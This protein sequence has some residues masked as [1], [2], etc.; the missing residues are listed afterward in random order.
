MRFGTYFFLQAT[1]DRPAAQVVTDEVA[2]MVLSEQLGFDSVWLTEHH[3]ADYGLSAAPSVL[4]ATVAARTTRIAIGTAVYVLPFQ[5][6][7]RLAEE[8]A[9]LDILSGGRLIVGIGRGN[10][11]REFVGHGIDQAENRSRMT[12]GV[13]LLLAAWT[14]P[15][16]SFAGTHW[17]VP[18]ITVNPKP[19]QQPHPPV[20]VAAT[21]DDTVAWTA[22]H[23]FR[24][25]SSGLGT[26]LPALVRLR[27]LYIAGLREAG[28]TTPDIAALLRHW[29]VTKH[30]YVAETDAQA[31]HEAEAH[32]RWYLEAFARSLRA[33]DLPVS[34]EIRA[35]ADAMASRTLSRQWEDLIDD[36]LL[37]GSPATVRARIAAL[38]EAGVGEV[39]CWMNFGGLA[40]AR[41]RRSMELFA[42]EVMPA[43]RSADPLAQPTGAYPL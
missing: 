37:I 22:A 29:V 28:Y 23:G 21:S 26:P 14:Q 39:A 43:L 41:V 8:T 9:T 40:D 36:V 3:Y 27:D 33:D 34:A 16:V 1:P 24:L 19:V 18:G 2:Q 11:A 38:A 6:P 5:H 13:E 32:E 7:L 31:R 42:T 4:A 35:Q 30:V 17:T 10:R 12:E 20:A 25:L 15:R